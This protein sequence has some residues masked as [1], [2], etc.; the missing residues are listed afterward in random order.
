[1][2]S[3]RHWSDLALEPIAAAVVCSACEERHPRYA[4]AP[5][6]DPHRTS[7]GNLGEKAHGRRKPAA[8][9]LSEA[10]GA[11]GHNNHK[12]G[13]HW[14]TILELMRFIPAFSRHSISPLRCTLPA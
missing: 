6:D 7:P 3:N 10:E 5:V 12:F 14:R 4:D 11:L 9:I 2:S 1:V 13:R 8:E